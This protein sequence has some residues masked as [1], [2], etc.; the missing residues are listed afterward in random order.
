MFFSFL[1]AIVSGLTVDQMIHLVAV[2][3]LKI[4]EYIW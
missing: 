1:I 3:V 4:L 2:V